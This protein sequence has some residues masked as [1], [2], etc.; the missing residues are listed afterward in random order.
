MLILV[1]DE[2]EPCLDASLWLKRQM[3]LSGL[4][5]YPKSG[6][7]LNL[8]LPDQFNDDI[9]AFLTHVETGQ[10]KPR[11]QTEFSSMFSPVDEHS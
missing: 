2:D 6:H 4:K 7:L 5:I 3:P 10:W 8:E 9:M 11:S 1:G